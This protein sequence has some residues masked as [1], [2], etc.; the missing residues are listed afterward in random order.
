MEP[1]ASPPRASISGACTPEARG[2]SRRTA[3]SMRAGKKQN[4]STMDSALPQPG[5]HCP[6]S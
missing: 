1:P 4:F 3:A 5:W 6:W 2:P